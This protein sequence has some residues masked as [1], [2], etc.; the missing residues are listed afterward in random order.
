MVAYAFSSS[1]LEAEAGRS[2]RPAWTAERLLHRGTLSWRKKKKKVEQQTNKAGC[3][4]THTFPCSMV[5]GTKEVVI[6]VAE[7]LR[8][9]Q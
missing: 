9:N 2:L 6:G 5:A 4:Y 8:W 3:E 1:T 7:L